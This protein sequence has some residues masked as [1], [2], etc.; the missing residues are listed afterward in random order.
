MPEPISTTTIT[1]I[2]EKIYNRYH[3]DHVAGSVCDQIVRISQ[4]KLL[5]AKQ[6][7]KKFFEILQ[8]PNGETTAPVLHP[9]L[10]EQYNISQ[11]FPEEPQFNNVLLSPRGILHHN[12]NCK[13]PDSC[14]C[15]PKLYICEKANCIQN[16]KIGKLPKFS[17]ANGNWVGQLPDNISDMTYGSRV[18]MRPVQTFGRIVSFGGSVGPGGSRLTGHVYS[19]KL[20]TALVVKKVPLI[21]AQAPVRVLVVTPFSSDESALEQG[22]RASIKADY[23]VEPIKIRALHQ[24]WKDVDNEIM[25]DISFDENTFENLPN[26][27]ISPDVF[28]VERTERTGTKNHAEESLGGPSLLRSAEEEIEAPTVTCTVTIGRSENNGTEHEQILRVLPSIPSTNAYVVRPNQEFVSD[29]D[30]KYLETHYPDLFP[31]ARGGFG[32]ERKVRI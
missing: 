14:R 31:F 24:F 8:V 19:T 22:K 18:L 15:K 3:E 16:L 32:E 20:K 29:S 11:F 30:P 2:T 5:T 17:I 12:L 25:K 1:E 21:P 7:P 23:I 13:H 4:V 9:S 28:L 10:I 27:D 26:N 6:L